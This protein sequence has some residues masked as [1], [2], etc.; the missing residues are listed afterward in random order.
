MNEQ[1]EGYDAT[2]TISMQQK[3]KDATAVERLIE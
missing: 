1:K 3:E 2:D